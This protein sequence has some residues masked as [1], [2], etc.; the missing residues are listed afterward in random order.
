MECTASACVECLI[1]MGPVFS[2]GIDATCAVAPM[3]R[4]E[5]FDCDSILGDIE[6]S[7]V[8]TS[9]AGEVSRHPV[10]P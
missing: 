5:L 9:R 10:K 7:E 1:L 3:C 8:C 2:E 4:S 6:V